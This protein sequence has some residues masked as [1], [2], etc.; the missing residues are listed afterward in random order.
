MKDFFFKDYVYTFKKKLYKVVKWRATLNWH[1]RRWPHLRL[2][3]PHKKVTTRRMENGW[4]FHDTR[5]PRAT[6]AIWNLWPPMPLTP[7][8]CR[9]FCRP[10][11]NGLHCNLWIQ[12]QILYI[13]RLRSAKNMHFTQIYFWHLLIRASPKLK[14]PN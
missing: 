2:C 10:V 3:G 9:H 11:R 14:L 7:S 6:T 8:D 12:T 1:G 4:A 13:G 5:H